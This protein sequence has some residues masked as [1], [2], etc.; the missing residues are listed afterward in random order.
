MNFN[1][2]GDQAI[3]GTPTSQIFN[4]FSVT[5]S[6]GTLSTTGGTTSLDINGS[7]TITAGAFTAPASITLAGNFTQD[8]GSTF[9]P[10]AGTVTFDGGAGQSIDGTL[11]TKSFFGFTVSKGG[12][13]LSPAA[14][15]TALD[16]NGPF[17]LTAGTFAAGTA[18]TI[19]VA[20][21]WTHNGG[22]FTPGVAA[23][24]VIF[25]GGAGQTTGGTV[26][27]IFNNLTNAN[28]N[29]LAMANDNTVNGILALT[30]SDITVANTKT[31]TQPNTGSSSGTFDVIG[32]VKRTGFAT[33]ACRCSLCNTLSFGNPDNQITITAGTAPTDITVNLVKS[34]P[35]GFS[36]AV[37]RTYT[38]TP[39]GGA[40]ITA[41]L[42]LHYL[43]SELNSNA[44]ASLNLRR[45]NGTGWAPYPA[46][47][48][49]TNANWVE[50]NAVQTFSPWTL[51]S[52]SPTASDGTVSG[53][54]TA[55]DGTPV[56]GAV[57][58]LS[59]TQNRK[60]I[61]DANGFY[62]FDNVDTNGFYTVTPSR[63][64]YTFNPSSRSFSQVGA[65][66]E[67][68][69][70][71]TVTSSELVN[72]LDTPEYFVR[73][74]YL[75]FLGREPDE[76][77]FNFWS[78]QILS[79]GGDSD[80]V[81]RKR[82]NVSA[83]YFLSIEFQETGGLVDGLYRASYG[84]RPDFDEFK[85]DAAAVAPAL[86]VGRAGWEEALEN[87]KTAFVNAF[88]QRAAFR[89]AFDGT[90][91]ETYIDALIA[92]TGVS[93]TV[94]ERNAL[95]GGLEAGTMTRAG[96]LRAIVQ[97]AD[98]VAAKR[99]EAFVMMEYFGYLRREPDPL[100]YQFWLDKLNQFN[101]NFEQAEMVRAFIVSIEYRERFPR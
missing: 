19:N 1:G 71:S 31:L 55:S 20:G 39:N 27:T 44:E 5:K 37:Q 81:D 70:D 10:G 95:V 94:A 82:T 22:T 6:G 54:I 77:G 98:V 61:T 57:V 32:S 92:N 16:I 15:T 45:F 49:D 13:T 28:A 75:D 84:E 91:N 7:L 18:S 56:A 46:T 42:R 99:N 88:V 72:P 64:N 66:T 86:V 23:E 73:Q 62:R 69:F 93:F 30:S 3:G 35:A 100:G 67:A 83:A 68:A 79:C 59:G 17:T 14:G 101:G 21:N 24:T 33:A 78:D 51:S 87:G 4:N 12:G 26:A 36:S 34:A 58:R 8:T 11:A 41:T 74:N 50:N 38:I 2:G 43:Q 89:A 52:F 53:R 90:S 47:A 96:A 60:F 29:G 76:A 9:T 85:A 40:G 63:A 97:D 65:V 48:A 80:C 25:D